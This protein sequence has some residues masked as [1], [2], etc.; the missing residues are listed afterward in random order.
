VADSFVMYK[1]YI[2]AAR[3]FPKDKQLAFYDWI[4]DYAIYDVEPDFSAEPPEM[5]FALDV[6]FGQIKTSITASIKR[7][8]ACVENG[9]KGGR[10]KGTKNL[11]NQTENQ[12]KNQCGN[13]TQNQRHNLNKNYNLNDNSY[14]S[15]SEVGPLGAPTS[16]THDGK[17][18]KKS[19][20]DLPPYMRGWRPV[21]E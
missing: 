5:Q 6:V 21:I 15:V 7:Y 18:E 16:S 20:E 2:E 12:S 9:K 17:E 1:S 14:Y 11:K 10:P 13:Q 3:K 8:E 4:I 19:E